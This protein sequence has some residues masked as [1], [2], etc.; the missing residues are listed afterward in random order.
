MFGPRTQRFFRTMAE[1]WV[2]PFVA[3]GITPNMVT[4]MGFGMAVLSAWAIAA[5]HLITAAVLLFVGG[6]FD[7]SDGALARVQGSR[8]T[9][10]AFFDSTLDRYSESV[11]LLGLAYHFAARSQLT[12]LT[13]V[14][15]GLVGSLMVS[16]TRARAEGLGLECKEGFYARPERVMTLV[17]G[18]LLYP[19]LLW[20][21]V[22]LAVLAN[23]TAVQRIHHVWKL[24]HPRQ[25]EPTEPSPAAAGEGRVRVPRPA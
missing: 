1:W 9:F 2:R 4:T 19:W 18:L 16:Y 6:A 5:N 23:V 20:F 8:S 10:G 12:E 17:L 22:L 11:V 15:A 24:T 21:L 25:P 13:V 14:F 3:L 7:L